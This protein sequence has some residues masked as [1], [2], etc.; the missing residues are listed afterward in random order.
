MSTF[1]LGFVVG[2]VLG[3]GVGFALY[4]TKPDKFKQ[5][6]DKAKQEADELDAKLRGD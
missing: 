3:F 1:I 4:L 2:A 5:L 6:A